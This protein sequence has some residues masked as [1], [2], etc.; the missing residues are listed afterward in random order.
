VRLSDV[1]GLPVLDAD[2]VEVGRVADLRLVRSGPELGNFGPAYAIEGLIVNPG[3][4][5]SFY[6][7]ERGDVSHPMLLGWLF[8][9][10]HKGSRYAAWESVVGIG[11]D[12]VTL[13]VR[14]DD[15]PALESLSDR[16]SESRSG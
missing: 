6:G 7:Y 3:R 14:G 10:L 9:K 1:L 4:R 5:G 12:G 11:D 13:R 2:G 8:D 15:L 16:R